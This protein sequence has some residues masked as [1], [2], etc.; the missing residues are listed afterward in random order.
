MQELLKSFEFLVKISHLFGFFPFKLTSNGQFVLS[1]TTLGYILCI[2]VVTNVIVVLQVMHMDQRKI[3]AS[4]M[5]QFSTTI[6]LVMTEVFG[7]IAIVS[8]FLHF[9]R[10]K[11]FFVNLWK[12]DMKVG[13]TV[14]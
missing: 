3:G 2:F 5:A 9:E 8:N 10:I 1:K 4:F 11:A 7:A 6:V 13:W 14:N 12:V